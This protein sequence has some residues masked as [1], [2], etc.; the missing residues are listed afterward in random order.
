VLS[1]GQSGGVGGGQGGSSG[2]GGSRSA[3]C[4]CGAARGCAR[5]AVPTVHASV[6]ASLS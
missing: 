5:K 4:V 2:L 1:E 3:K 6:L